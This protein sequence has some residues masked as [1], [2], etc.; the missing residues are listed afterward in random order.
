MSSRCNNA[1][2]SCVVVDSSM[3]G[4]DCSSSFSAIA[5]EINRERL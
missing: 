4:G 5:D 3:V 1:A 2:I